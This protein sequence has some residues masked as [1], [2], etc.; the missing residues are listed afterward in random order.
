M[1]VLFV[2]TCY[3]HTHTQVMLECHHL[4]CQ[5]CAQKW[6][7][8]HQTCPVCRQHSYYYNRYLRS[9]IKNLPV[10]VP[11]LLELEKSYQ[12][13]Y[14]GTRSYIQYIYEN[15]LKPYI[16]EH[17]DVWYRPINYGCMQE[18][19][20]PILILSISCLEREIDQK[21][22]KKILS[23]MKKLPTVFKLN[24]SNSW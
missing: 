16:M 12:R 4:S 1:Y 3:I 8:R 11:F 9:T 24:Q 20:E 5:K 15:I 13:T 19:L 7:I 18:I 23:D 2:F 10:I 17:L 22:S 21:E 6:V 14:Q